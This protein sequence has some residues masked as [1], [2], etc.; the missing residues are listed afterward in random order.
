MV[1]TAKKDKSFLPDTGLEHAIGLLRQE[2]KIAER[3]PY[4]QIATRPDG[5]ID[6]DKTGDMSKACLV[7]TAGTTATGVIDPLEPAG[8]AKWTHVDAAWAGP[9]RLSLTHADLLDGINEADSVSVSAHK[10]FFQPKEDSFSLWAMPITGVTV[11]RPL[12]MSTE[13]FYQRLPEGI[14]STCML[15]NRTWLRSV[16]ANPLADIEEIISILSEAIRGNKH[17][18]RHP[19]V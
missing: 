3:L 15:D 6:P 10:W 8:R 11:F 7:L 12:S 18:N 5:R 1:M 16:A 13:K 14:F 17:C 19:V 2:S 4:E 9:L